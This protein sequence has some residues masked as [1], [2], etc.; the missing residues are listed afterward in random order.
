[1]N[2]SFDV[3]QRVAIVTGGA[4]GIGA[5]VCEYLAAAGHCVLVADLPGAGHGS[6]MSPPPPR[7]KLSGIAADLLADPPGFDR[8]LVAPAHAQIVAF[9]RQNL[10]P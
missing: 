1:M 3:E 8:T 7:E 2:E 5:Q 10:L 9:F 6:L 4:M